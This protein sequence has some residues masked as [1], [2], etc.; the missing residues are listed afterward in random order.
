MWLSSSGTFLIISVSAESNG[1]SHKLA[2]NISS[3]PPLSFT[4][5]VIN[6]YLYTG[7][8]IDNISY[9]Y[10]EGNSF[11]GA[12]FI[13]APDLGNTYTIDYTTIRFW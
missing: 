12:R 3:E 1:S 4:P 10:V 5:I 6:A 9:E 13:G 11:F 7:S 2:F 8:G